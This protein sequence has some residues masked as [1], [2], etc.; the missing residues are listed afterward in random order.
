MCLREAQ[1]ERDNA[2]RAIVDTCPQFKNGGQV[3]PRI[4][5]FLSKI[6]NGSKMRDT[7]GGSYWGGRGCLET[8]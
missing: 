2:A 3:S 5:Y 7:S 4:L 8:V 1:R 6:L